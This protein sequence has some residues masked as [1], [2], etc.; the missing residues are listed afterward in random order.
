MCD[1]CENNKTIMKTGVVS[2]PMI[3]WCG[4]IKAKDLPD[5]EYQL[6]VFIDSRGYLRMVDL[7]DCN[8]LEGGKKMKIYFCPFCGNKI[9]QVC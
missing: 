9:K 5:L 8:C 2:T 7:N 1:F 6:G 4:E 3:G